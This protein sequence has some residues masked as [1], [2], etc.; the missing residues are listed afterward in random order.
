MSIMAVERALI[1]LRYITDH[2]EGL[3]I[4]EASRNLGY[5]PATVQKIISALHA[6]GFV[7][8]DQLTERYHLGPEAIQLG[9][10]ALSR[11]DVRRAAR[12]YLEDLNK[13]TGETVF[14]A[15]SR[16]NYAVYVDKVVSDQP[17]RMDAPLGDDR[18]LNCTAVGKVL[19]TGVADEEI[20]QW[21]KYFARKTENSITDIEQLKIEIQSVRQR[22]WA[23][24]HEEYAYGVVCIAAPVYNHEQKIIAA[25]TVSGPSSRVGQNKELIVELIQQYAQAIS[26][27][28]GFSEQLVV[29]GVKL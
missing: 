7:V 23:Q 11:L 10:S 1:L 18:P 17:I 21:N 16:S 2:E 25:L 29:G 22:G 15:I 12:P 8:Q 27:E 28:M 6:Q 4:R 26:R 20:A 13:E 9:L 5:S 19:L 3:S 14:L 24:D